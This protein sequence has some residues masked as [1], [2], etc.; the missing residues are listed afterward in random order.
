MNTVT[1]CH[2]DNRSR[3]VRDALAT[4]DANPLTEAVKG[5]DVLIKPNYNTADPAPG[6][7]DN[8]TLL[9]LIDEL[10]RIGAGSITVG[11]R[12]WRATADTMARKGILPHLKERGVEV[13]IFD[14]LPERDWIELKNPEFNWPDGFKVARPVVEAEC[15][16]ET[17][18]LKT[19]Q[20][21][22]VFTLSLKLAVGC[23]PGQGQDPK[24]MGALHGSP[25]QRRMIAEINTAFTPALIV[26][27]GIDAFVDGGPA[28]GKRAKGD[29][30]LAARNRVAVDAVGL[31]CLKHLGSNPTIMDRPIFAQDQIA[32][33]VELGLGPS[34][35]GEID[36]RAADTDS[37]DYVARLAAIGRRG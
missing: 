9:A 4:L 34:S 18:C 35:W 36:L 21:G 16:V 25:H 5:K 24:Y 15:L 19:H 13:I 17:C 31:A 7:T 28:T 11:E 26:L 27:D 1:L 14:D 8:E 2:T 37:R 6:S 12:S 32:R 30:V 22:G 10:W 20:F 33:A 3:G 29:V 23:L